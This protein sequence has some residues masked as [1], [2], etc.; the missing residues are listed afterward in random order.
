[1]PVDTLGYEVGNEVAHRAYGMGI[2]EELNEDEIKL[3]FDDGTFRSF[4]L[5]VL[6]DN[7][8]IRRVADKVCE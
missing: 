1:M 8:L 7:N 4:S 3:K 6:L 5:K 2:V